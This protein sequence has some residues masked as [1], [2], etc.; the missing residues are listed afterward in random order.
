MTD[1]LYD[2]R[3]Q[4]DFAWT[5][6]DDLPSG[7]YAA[8]VVAAEGETGEDFIPFFVRRRGA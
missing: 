5:I 6:P 1:D 7:V 3:W 8:H 2:C 4:T